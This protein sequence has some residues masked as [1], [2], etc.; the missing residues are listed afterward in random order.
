MYVRESALRQEIIE[1]GRLMYDKDLICGIDGN[2]SARL[3]EDRIL[4]TPSG[5]PKGL[6][7]QDQLLI[8][9]LDGDPVRYLNAQSHGLKPT[10]ELPMHLEVYRQRPDV[11]AIVHA[12]PPLSVAL[13]IAGIPMSLAML[14]EVILV[15]GRIPTAPYSLPSSEENATAIRTL[16]RDHDAIILERHGSLTVGDSPMHAFLRLESVEQNARILFMLAQLGGGDP[17]RAGA[18]L[19]PAE[20]ARLMSLRAKMGLGSRGA[21]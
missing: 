11:R 2:I 17:L 12:H 16:I 10:S 5:L 15:L 18:E 4:I 8:V 14:P 1:V 13:S 7:R 3:S 19:D 21:Y 9:D 20:L 6:L